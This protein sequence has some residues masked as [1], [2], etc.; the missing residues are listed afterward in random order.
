MKAVLHAAIMS[1]PQ[2]ALSLQRIRHAPRAWAF[3]LLGIHRRH[4]AWLTVCF[5][6]GSA[7]LS[8]Q[9]S[10]ASAQ[11]APARLAPQFRTTPRA[12]ITER[13]DASRRLAIPG[14]VHPATA[15][16]QDLG[17]IDGAVS[18]EH[19]QL[20]LRRP[21]ERQAALDALVEAQNDPASPSFHQWLTPEQIGAEFGPAASDLTAI[22]T[23]LQ[24][25]GFTVNGISQSQMWIDFA[26]SSSVVKRS[27]HTGLHRFRV[28]AGGVYTSATQAAELPAALLPAVAAIVSLSNFPFHAQ[29]HLAPAY[30]VGNAQLVG[31]Q[32][33]YTIYNELP[34]L[35]GGAPINGTGQTIAL[36]ERTNINVD[37]VTAFRNSFEVSPPAPILTV[38]HGST[39][40]V[41]GN[42]GITSTDE[43]TEAVLDTEWAGAVA[44]SASLLFMSCASSQSTDGILLS[45]ESVIDD[46]LAGILSLS[47][48]ES[49][50][51][52]ASLGSF[53]SNLYEQA[54]AQGQTVVVSSG[55][56]GSDAESEGS[57]VARHGLNVNV[58]GSSAYNISAGG[59]DFQD[60]FNQTID[61]GSSYGVSAFWN[62]TSSP[63]QLTAKGYVPETTW[64]S[65]CASSLLNAAKEG[66][67]ASPLALCDDAAQRNAYLEPMAG[68]GGQSLLNVRPTWQTGTVYGLPSTSTYSGRLLPDISLFASDGVW[69]HLL[70]F[71]QSDR[72]SSMES[73]GGTSFVAPQLAGVFALIAQKTRA[74]VGLAN[75]ELYNLA[76]QQFG[77]SSYTG[78]ACNGSGASGSGETSS[79]PSGSCLFYD[80][81]TGNNS[82][83]CRSGSPNCYTDLG[84]PYGLLSTSAA[85]PLPAY[86]AGQGYDLATGIG[87]L[88]IQNLVN[89]WIFTPLLTSTT[90]VLSQTTFPLNT[91]VSFTSSVTPATGTVTPTG[92]VELATAAVSFLDASAVL[93]NGR[94]T[95]STNNLPAGT[96]TVFAKYLGDSDF[97]PSFSSALSVT[98]NPQATVTALSVNPSTGSV[99]SS[100]ALLSA[101]LSPVSLGTFHASGTISFFDGSTSLCNAVSVDAVTGIATCNT[102]ALTVGTHI[103]AAMY[104]GDTNFAASTSPAAILAVAKATPKINVSNPSII[105]GASSSAISASLFF[106][107][108]AA[109]TG[110]L[111]FTVD[112]GQP[113]PALCA[114]STYPVVCTATYA[115]AGLSAGTH[116]INA[117]LAADANYTAAS[118]TGSLSISAIAPV[119]QFAVPPQT[120]GS[121]PFSLAAT[122][123]SS[124]PFAYSVVSGPVTV[125]GSTVTLTGIGTVVL[126][127]SEAAAGNYAAATQS[128]TFTVA[129]ASAVWVGNANGTLSTFSLSGAALSPAA[130]FSG[131]G[132]GTAPAS[133]GLAFDATG[134]LW[135]A[136]SGSGVSE[137]NNTGAPLSAHPYTAGGIHNPLA[138]AVD[139]AGQIWIA[140]GNGSISA[141]VNTGVALSPAT[142][143]TGAGLSTPG[144]IAVDL[145]GNVWVSNSSDNSVTEIL[146]VAAPIAPLATAV[147]NGTTGA[148]P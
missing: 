58:L 5:V 115:T 136:N 78:S 83:A 139:G 86:T 125:S 130:G 54:A 143:F 88:N 40:V 121:V 23:Y 67:S 116:T 31:A 47:Y 108:G 28:H 72:S 138:L 51:G 18:I 27:L 73:G 19:I 15:S 102:P 50:L 10:I 118:A 65:T 53:I 61:G 59:T 124:G 97:A 11:T 41:C 93:S 141:L 105:Y 129:A 106:S 123:N 80:I 4:P 113:V 64:N 42:P 62:A 79:L 16:A 35:Q 89:S 95:G 135:I 63:G 146:G 71:Y 17:E 111:T 94:T 137:F 109:P 33:F 56:S 12:L 98:V 145:S 87:S 14:A 36:I 32:D 81:Q 69:G 7:W 107:F 46:N 99:Y 26:G 128:A 6:L 38:Q 22:I 117:N 100:F 144:G 147:A 20:A 126:A 70:S 66:R 77:T 91:S 131:G 122:S 75:V 55:D 29:H 82:V 104:A 39:S 103:F 60:Q 43:E 25:E 120:Y 9:V 119:I 21:P 24:S 49:E 101:T 37:D 57:N 114:G 3:A 44:P 110:A 85:G 68:S 134:N 140:N 8:A 148:R 142:G 90:L 84:Q 45:A 74:R 48:G 92:T 96:Y 132:L 34:L 52:E 133:L 2:S 1:L 30:T 112:G 13:V 76:G 127:A